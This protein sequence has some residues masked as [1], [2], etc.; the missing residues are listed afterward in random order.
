MIRQYRRYRMPNSKFPRLAFPYI[1]CNKNNMF[2]KEYRGKNS[3][4]SVC[5]YFCLTY[6]ILCGNRDMYDINILRTT[7]EGKK[8]SKFIY[9]SS[10]HTLIIYKGC[11]N[12]LSVLWPKVHNRKRTIPGLLCVCVDMLSLGFLSQY[13]LPG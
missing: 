1:R 11:L 3:D 4:S 5:I 7:Q 10:L 6:N 12:V 8:Y 13:G 2:D 9:M